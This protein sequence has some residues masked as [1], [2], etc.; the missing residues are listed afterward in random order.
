[1]NRLTIIVVGTLAS[2]PYAGMAWM[3]MQIVV[4][5]LRLGHNVFYFEVTST[6]PHNPKLQMRV[7]NPGYSVPYLRGGR[8]VWNRR[9]VGLSV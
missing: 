3:N 9:Q 5:L 2:D 4:G 7:D 8:R 1:M 6:W